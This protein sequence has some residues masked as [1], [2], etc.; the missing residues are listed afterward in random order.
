MADNVAITA[1]SG[2]TIAADDVGSG[3]LH[4]RVKVTHGADGTGTDASATTPLPVQDV[5][6]SITSDKKQVTT[7]GTRVALASTAACRAVAITALDTNLGIVVVGGTDVVA[8]AG[9]QATPTRKGIPLRPLDTIVVPIK[10]PSLINIDSL[11]SADGVSF[12]VLA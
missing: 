10:D 2:T 9:T 6:Q 5:P 11:N 4:Q 7:A 12:V 1:G 8:A 3:V